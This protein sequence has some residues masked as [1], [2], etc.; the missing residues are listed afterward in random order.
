MGRLFAEW[1]AHNYKLVCRRR[2]GSRRWEERR[3]SQK[4]YAAP[5][6]LID[7]M[8]LREHVKY[9]VG[10]LDMAGGLFVEHIIKEV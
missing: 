6:L 8:H 5:V 2:M 10:Q 1:T 7:A 3:R 9:A 4:P